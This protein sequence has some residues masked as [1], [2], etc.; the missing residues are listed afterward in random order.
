MKISRYQQPLRAVQSYGPAP[1]SFVICACINVCVR[2][3]LCVCI[4]ESRWGAIRGS[5]TAQESCDG[6]SG[7]CSHGIQKRVP[8]SSLATMFLWLETFVTS[9]YEL[10]LSSLVIKIWVYNIISHF[11]CLP[12][13]LTQTVACALVQKLKSSRHVC[14]VFECVETCMQLCDELFVITY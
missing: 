6:G 12:L 13:Y 7:V 3:C 4:C 1:L 8:F 11:V 14:A 9:Q 2:V 10:I 5:G